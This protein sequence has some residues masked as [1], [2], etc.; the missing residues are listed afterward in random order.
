MPQP[1]NAPHGRERLS[2]AGAD[3]E[4][5]VS[6]AFHDRQ[7]AEMRIEAAELRRHLEAIRQAQ[8]EVDRL[9]HL[10]IRMHVDGTPE[11]PRMAAE[12]ALAAAQDQLA[13]IIHVGPPEI[14][15]QVRQRYA[16]D[17]DGWENEGGAPAPDRRHC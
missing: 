4:A 2:L 11:A 7:M 10:V 13:A 17:T 8:N 16:T 9:N 15:A 14:I 12:R 6:A 1:R 3:A 5:V